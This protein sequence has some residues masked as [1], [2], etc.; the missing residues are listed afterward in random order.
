MPPLM[1][2]LASELASRVLTLSPP[3][4]GSSSPPNLGLSVPIPSLFLLAERVKPSLVLSPG[5]LRSLAIFLAWVLVSFL[6]GSL[7]IFLVG[8]LETTT[9]RSLASELASRVLT[10]SPPVMGLPVPLPSSFLLAV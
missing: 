10:S 8:V 3:S 2:S 6:T 9:V 1:R 4:M 7:V 5:L